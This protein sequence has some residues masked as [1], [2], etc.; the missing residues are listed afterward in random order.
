MNVTVSRNGPYI[1]TGSVPLR[2]MEICN[3]AEGNCR[4]WKTVHEFPLQ[5]QYALC[6]CGHSKN[7]PFCDG[8]HAKIHFDGTET[9]G[10]EAYLRHPDSIEGE[11][12]RL[13]DVGNLCVHARFC[14]RAGGIWNLTRNSGI[15]EARDTA[16]EEA[17][18]CPSGRLVVRDRK[19]GRAIE[20]ELEKSIVLIE[21][22][23]RHEHGPLWVRGGIPV[24]SA[25]GESYEVRNR[26]TLCRC[27]KSGNKPFCDGS[28][29]RP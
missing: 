2:T 20:P 26:V 25:D 22:P 1:V 18:N 3:D 13:E 14:M 21:Y 8:T 5:E 15:P 10:N 24:V 12:L 9:A 16:I 29:I 6:R 23:A 4:T 11:E 19:S 7:K 27:G 28:H 17:C